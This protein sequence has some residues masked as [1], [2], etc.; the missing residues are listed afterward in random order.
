MKDPFIRPPSRP[1]RPISF[2]VV[3]TTV[4]ML[5]FPEPATAAV[6]GTVELVASATTITFGAQVSLS[7]RVA[8]GGTCADGRSLLLE[9][10]L[11]E[12]SSFTTIGLGVTDV[13]GTFSFTQA[14]SHTGSF[15]VTAPAAGT[16]EAVVSD[17]APVR[18]RA[19]VNDTFPAGALT[20]GSCVGITTEVSPAKPGQEVV[21]QQRA[22]GGWEERDALTLDAT[23]RVAWRPCFGWEDIGVVRL[24]TRWVAQDAVNE[25]GTGSVLSLEIEPAGWME[26]IDSLIDGRSVSLSV[27]EGGGFLYGRAPS[28]PRTP[29]SNEKLLL[30]MVL[31]DAFDVGQRFETHVASTATPSNGRLPGDVWILGRGDPEVDRRSM[32]ELAG[33]IAAAGITRIAGRVMGSTTYFRRDWDAKGW[34]DAA[35]S[36][37]A[38][39]T[40]LTFEGNLD[41]HG[42]NLRNPEARAAEVL[43]EELEA[44]GVRVAGRPGSGRAPSGLTQL[45]SIRSR[46]L[47]ALLTKMLRPSD[48][49]I[50]EVLGK[51]LGVQV[52]GAPGS[53]GKGATAIRTWA[54]ARDVFFSLFDCSGLSYENRVTTEGL[55]QLLWMSE[56]SPWGSDLFDVLPRGGQGTLRHRLAKVEV[57]AKTGT[58]TGIS[59]LSGWVWL[60]H[61]GAWGEFSILSA[62][63]SKPVASDLEDRIVRILQRQAR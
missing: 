19:R 38:R 59:A 22:G 45:A 29:A 54:Q 57:R 18:V 50:A 42:R 44:L 55:V 39:P 17:A 43:T 20:A 2:V 63:M 56:A 60:E 46:T 33:R 14:P 12:S 25:T 28:A 30:S 62:G 11:A 5:L 31:L 36:Y 58:L 8:A 49:F 40:A 3:V 26:R 21:L 10:R 27:G 32:T 52:A 24:R 61:L 23:S 53:I 16:C 41:A 1:A 9:W 47:K 35:R 48:N 51:R 34:N 7:G 15:R 13:G 6:G 4:A 37:V